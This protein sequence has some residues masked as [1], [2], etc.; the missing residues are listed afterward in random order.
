MCGA[1]SRF[2][3]LRGRATTASSAGVL[4]TEGSSEDPNP[5]GMSMNTGKPG[6]RTISSVSASVGAL[7]AAILVFCGG[8]AV[9]QTTTSTPATIPA[10][11]PAQAV[12]V[13][14]TVAPS[15]DTGAAVSEGTAKS[16]ANSG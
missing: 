14:T 16:S 2:F 15:G 5:Q 1:P 3:F 8:A 11:T 6:T 4:S 12:P 13:P 7:I 10:S 9:A